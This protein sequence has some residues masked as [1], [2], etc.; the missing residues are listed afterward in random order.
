MAGSHVDPQPGTRAAWLWTFALLAVSPVLSELISSLDDP[1]GSPS[2]LLA[3]LLIVAISR[4]D[5][6]TQHRKAGAAI[7]IAA[8]GIELVGLWTRIGSLARLSVPATLVGVSLFT[9]RPSLRSAILFLWTFPLPTFALAQFSPGLESAVA[10]ASA[11][12]MGALGRPVEVGGPLFRLSTGRLKLE[13]FQ[14]GL[15]LGILCAEL[16][17][18]WGLRREWTVRRS[19]VVTILAGLLGPALQ[20]VGVTVAISVALAGYARGA[21]LWLDYGFGLSVAS[22]VVLGAEWRSPSNASGRCGRLMP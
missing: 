3:P 1:D 18:Y 4:N 9:G 13:S 6:S 19:L 16:A 11:S 7:L 14:S 22:T 5:A 12:V 20:V 21:Q 10:H 8:V 17:W 15:P 2:V